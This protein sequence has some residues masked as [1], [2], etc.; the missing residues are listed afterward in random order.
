MEKCIRYR[1]TDYGVE[2]VVKKTI[3]KKSYVPEKT[4]ARIRAMVES[5]KGQH[6]SRAIMKAGLESTG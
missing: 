4:K 5:H 1:K 3:C 6:L 2:L